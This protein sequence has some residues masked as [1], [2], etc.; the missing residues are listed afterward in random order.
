MD[1]KVKIV[2]DLLKK[3]RHSREELLSIVGIGISEEE[4]D[5]I[6]NGL[7]EKNFIYKGVDQKYAAIKEPFAVGKLERNNAGQLFVTVNDTDYIIPE[8]KLHAAFKDDIVVIDVKVNGKR[9]RIVKRI[10]GLPGETVKYD[11]NILYIN[12]KRTHD[13]FRMKTRDY[14]LSKYTEYD[15]IPEGYYFVLGDNRTNSM[16]S[17]DY[18]IGL[19][20]KSQILGKPIFRI[21]PFNKIGTI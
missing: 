6:L 1:N 5:F 15:K 21:W 3:F 16:D 19:V 9:E 18:K 10:I 12:G 8:S 13:D 11:N 7:I 17:R 2:L 4:L 20:K 14:D